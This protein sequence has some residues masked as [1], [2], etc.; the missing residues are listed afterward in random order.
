MKIATSSFCCS[1]LICAVLFFCFTFPA[2]ASDRGSN[3]YHLQQKRLIAQ[4]MAVA[5]AVALTEE[6][7]AHVQ[8][9]LTS[10][11]H[12]D[13]DIV[14][15]ALRYTD[16]EVVVKSSDLHD[17]W[18]HLPNGKS[19]P[20][21]VMLPLYKGSKKVAVV[22]IQFEE[23][24]SRDNIGRYYFSETVPALLSDLWTEENHIDLIKIALSTVKNHH[25]YVLSAAIRSKDGQI[26]RSVGEHGKYWDAGASDNILKK[27]LKTPIYIAGSE[28]ATFE[29]AVR[30]LTVR[31]VVGWMFF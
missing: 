6:K 11:V 25:H 8:E 14:S 30:P 27:Q 17:N 5:V 2:V 18:A 3:A 15:A 21:Q 1:K 23:S 13:F 16:S 29:V 12:E 10:V 28:V 22:E 20:K 24:D 9:L 4:N 19:T 31:E 7:T 26:V